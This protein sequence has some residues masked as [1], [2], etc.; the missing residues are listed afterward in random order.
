MKI[1]IFTG[2]QNVAWPEL[3]DL[4]LHA[5]AAGYD[6]AWTWDH[7]VALHGTI[8]DAHYEGWTLLAALAAQTE[9]LT[10]GHLVTAN[11]FRHPALLANMA[12]TV[13]HV[14]AG[15]LVVGIGTGY[16]AEE[17]DRLG[18]R[19]PPQAERAEMLAESVAIMRGLWAPGRF[20]F[21]GR[22]YQVADAPCEPRP[23]HGSIPILIGGAGGRTMRLAAAV[24][25]HWNLP[26]GQ[27]GIDIERLRTKVEALERYC[28]EAGRNP[29]EIERSMSLTVFVDTDAA[30]LERRYSAFRSY[31]GWDDETTRRHC[32]LGTPDQVV[33]E[34]RAFEANGLDHFMIHLVPG[35][36]YGDL[37]TFTEA[38]LPHLR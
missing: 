24:A 10:V 25:N 21:A 19:L 23:V 31:R 4:W 22:H 30:A 33:E 28:E 5:D 13:D 2:P 8:D 35:S 12:V 36:N 15:R 29:A 1:G 7:L 27:Y 37:L 17:H 14:S 16:Y 34:L 38:C 11:T 32:V 6:S 26:D 3:R 20:S 18:L 9:H